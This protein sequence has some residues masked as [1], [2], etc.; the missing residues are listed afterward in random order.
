MKSIKKPKKNFDLARKT[1]R[2]LVIAEHKSI[3]H[4]EPPEYNF[5]RVF[6]T[7]FAGFGVIAH[8]TI[9]KNQIICSYQGET[10]Q[11]EIKDGVMPKYNE[12]TTALAAK[13]KQLTQN[14]DKPLTETGQ[15]ELDE[16]ADRLKKLIRSYAFVLKQNHRQC[17]TVLSHRQAGIAAFVNCSWNGFA[18]AEAKLE[19]NKIVYRTLRDIQPNEEILIDYGCDYTDSQEFH[20]IFPIGSRSI[21][22]FLEQNA[23]HYPHLHQSIALDKTDQA[24]LGT[25]AT[26]VLLPHYCSDSKILKSLNDTEINLLPIIEMIKHPTDNK[27]IP[28]PSQQFITTLMYACLKPELS[29]NKTLF[30]KLIQKKVCVDFVTANG[31]SAWHILTSQYRSSAQNKICMKLSTAIYHVYDKR[32][33]A[34]AYLPY[35]YKNLKATSAEN[36]Q[37]IFSAILVPP[38]KTGYKRVNLI[39]EDSRQETSLSI[40]AETATTTEASQFDKSEEKTN[41]PTEIKSD[42]VMEPPSEL[43][44]GDSIPP[45]EANPLAENKLITLP[46]P[47]EKSSC[48]KRKR[49]CINITGEPVVKKQITEFPHPDHKEKKINIEMHISFL[50]AELRFRGIDRIFDK[51]DINIIDILPA[52]KSG[53]PIAA[54]LVLR[55]ESDCLEDILENISAPDD[56]IAFISAPIS[57]PGD[58]HGHTAL[59][60][61]LLKYSYYEKAGKIFDALLSE[62]IPRENFLK[63]MIRPLEQGVHKGWTPIALTVGNNNSRNFD[64]ILD[65]VLPSQIFA[66]LSTC[67]PESNIQGLNAAAIA[68]KF[69]HLDI[70][71]A[72]LWH[73]GMD[74]DQ[75]MALMTTPQMEGSEA[76]LTALEIAVK[77]YRDDIFAFLLEDIMSANRLDLIQKPLSNGEYQGCSLLA[78]AVMK[79][80]LPAVKALGETENSER[81]TDQ[82]VA[83]ITAP[84]AQGQY[85]GMTAI[86][87]SVQQGEMQIFDFLLHICNSKKISILAHPQPEGRFRGFNAISMAAYLKNAGVFSSLLTMIGKNNLFKLIN[88]RQKDGIVSA[89]GL[90]PFDIAILSKNLAIILLMLDTIPVNQKLAMFNTPHPA[91]S[92]HGCTNFAIAVFHQQFSIATEMLKDMNMDQKIALITS[93]QNGGPLAGL[94]AISIATKQAQDNFNFLN[95]L[96]KQLPLVK[97]VPIRELKAPIGEEKGFSVSDIA[98]KY[99]KYLQI[100]PEMTEHLRPFTEKLRTVSIVQNQS[101]SF[102]FSSQGSMTSNTT[103][104]SHS[105]CLTLTQTKTRTTL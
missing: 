22:R 92:F 20:H 26:H 60:I 78:V 5:L 59:T 11:Q 23:R 90:T 17:L 75:G 81:G 57:C 64:F 48:H 27:F 40:I 14:E 47:V 42:I 63:I 100:M 7:P 28:L 93:P 104:A 39:Q 3:T 88:L 67:Q 44:W 66:L 102:N 16:F 98:V 76:G 54:F 96:L 53:V 97:L 105:T 18:N 58:W 80:S 29:E 24:L 79:K 89:K 38:K 55:K 50:E 37:A 31:C 74:R 71:R 19:N 33:W 85:V 70:L 82:C 65:T 101:I 4:L 45:L 43:K 83:L 68:V 46:L 21:A 95:F 9:K 77:Y 51:Y 99:K 2:D 87:M 30:E 62:D 84:Q 36:Q 1:D 61:C 10:V 49:D 6:K 73:P 103:T 13:K 86:A 8:K 35:L 52:L 25:Q 34:D 72:I 94:T 41:P 91:G 56:K 12:I 15:E 69:R 32:G